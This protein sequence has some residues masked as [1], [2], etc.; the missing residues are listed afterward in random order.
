MENMKILPV[1]YPIITSY[2]VH[3]N[4]L[5]RVSNELNYILIS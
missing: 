5:S 4:I 1:N 3:A 2:P